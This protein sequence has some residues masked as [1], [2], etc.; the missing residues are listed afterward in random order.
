MIASSAA[1][2][3]FR[4]APS[5]AAAPAFHHASS[6][7]AVSTTPSVTQIP[8]TAASTI[9]SRLRPPRPCHRAPN[10]STTELSTATSLTPCRKSETREVLA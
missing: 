8:V 9:S 4:R 10:H 5:K 6:V 3:A 1:E 7:P 2:G